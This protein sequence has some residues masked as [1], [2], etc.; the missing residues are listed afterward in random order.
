MKKLIIHIGYPK[1]ATTSI[2]EGIF[3]E[4]HEANK[5]NYLGH[6]NRR[7]DNEIFNYAKKDFEDYTLKNIK[8]DVNKI[9]IDLSSSKINVLSHEGLTLPNSFLA[10]KHWRYNS[11][12]L[13]YPEKIAKI[14]KPITDDLK[15]MVTLRKQQEVIYSTY[16][17]LYNK[18]KY[19]KQFSTWNKY[20]KNGLIKNNNEFEI[21]YFNKI[22][23]LYAEWFSKDKINILFFEDFVNNK[24]E[25]LKQL[26]NI[27]ELGYKTMKNIKKDVHYKKKKKNDN[28]YIVNIKK[29]NFFSK[30]LL[31]ARKNKYIKKIYHIFKSKLGKNNILRKIFYK[32]IYVDNHS[33]PIP[34]EEEKDLIKNIFQ[35]DNIKLI[36]NFNID[37]EKLIKYKYI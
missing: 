25:F 12:P 30:M 20:L 3:V 28:E 37:K 19:D 23:N 32:G 6:T 22:L 4:L 33:I 24:E 1:T 34:T 10:K 35:D 18:F 26:S 36:K 8:K 5:I 14:F 11:N 27:I 2:Q 21:Y 9:K 17:Q 31:N 15:I 13:T 29:H 16:V 7:K